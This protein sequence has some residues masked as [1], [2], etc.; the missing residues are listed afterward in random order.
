MSGNF[1]HPEKRRL[2]N[3]EKCAE[4][5]HIKVLETLKWEQQTQKVIE[6]GKKKRPSWQVPYSNT[7]ITVG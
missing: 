1:S 4:R 3:N 2:G 5:I 7:L 6:P